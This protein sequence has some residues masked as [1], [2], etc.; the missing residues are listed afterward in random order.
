MSNPVE[1]PPQAQPLPPAL[2][3]RRLVRRLD[4]AA[5]A[6]TLQ[7]DD[8]AW[9]YAS[10]V[11]VACDIDA[12]PL[13]FLSDLAVH[14]KNLAFDP[15]ASLLFDGTGESDDPLTGARVTLLGRLTPDPS[16]ARLSRFIRRHPSAELY[17]GFK[18][19]HLYR[20]E[21]T[22]AHLVAGFGRIDW[23]DAANLRDPGDPAWLAAI[24]PGILLQMNAEYGAAFDLCA[25]RLLGLDGTGWQ[26]TGIDAEGAD[27]RNGGRAARLDFHVRVSSVDE[28]IQAFVILEQ[29]AKMRAAP[30]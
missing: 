11:L 13:L 29:S 7:D 18:D 12:S 3:A 24:E 23:I 15:R 8:G 14:A 4:R 25:K 20:M 5:L 19:F 17:A 28:T 9:P 22:R 27:L 30:H 2:A 26:L 6:T 16:A 10:F 1:T 21:L